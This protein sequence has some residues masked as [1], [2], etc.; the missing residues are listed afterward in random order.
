MSLLYSC[1]DR[2]KTSHIR[3]TTGYRNLTTFSILSDEQN[4]NTPT[5]NELERFCTVYN[6]EQSTTDDLP[7]KTNVTQVHKI[8]I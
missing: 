5:K 6:Q 3:D 2:T 4:Q 8:K 1:C 7:S